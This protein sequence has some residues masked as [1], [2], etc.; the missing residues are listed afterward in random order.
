MT[1]L[2]T[3]Y[4]VRHEN[5]YAHGLADCSLTLEGIYSASHELTKIL[6]HQKVNNIYCSPLL[7]TCQTIYGFAKEN[8][9]KIKLE[10][11]LYELV[12]RWTSH[13][14]ILPSIGSSLPLIEKTCTDVLCLYMNQY[15]FLQ[16]I[17]RKILKDWKA[18]EFE[19]YEIHHNFLKDLKQDLNCFTIMMNDDRYT[20]VTKFRYHYDNNISKI[21]E[22]ITY[23]TLY[24]DGLI[25]GSFPMINIANNDYAQ[26]YDQLLNMINESLEIFELYD[27]M[28][29][30]DQSY[31]SV[32]TLSDYF[33]EKKVESFGDSIKR[34]EYIVDKIMHCNEYQDS[35]FVS[36]L[37]TINALIVNFFKFAYNDPSKALEYLNEQFN[38]S[39]ESFESFCELNPIPIGSTHSV[40]VNKTTNLVTVKIL[41]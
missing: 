10:Q 26:S 34:T 38:E 39:Y 18:T 11:S 24:I 35:V 25:I 16:K 37:S 17:K 27:I 32:I 5:R 41:N 29:H 22:N 40:T 8:N 2:F 36:H 1:D 28:K 13:Y 14:A 30:I 19:S 20:Y 9:M 3:V 4:F 33:A 23:C 7:R 12:N 31:D 15:M 6:D 21:L